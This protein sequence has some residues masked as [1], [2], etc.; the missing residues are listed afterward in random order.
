MF[1]VQTD[2]ETYRI[3]SADGQ[4]GGIVEY[5]EVATLKVGDDIYY[6]CVTDPDT[7]DAD[8]YRVDSVSVVPSEIVEAEFEDEEDDDDETGDGET[9]DDEEVTTE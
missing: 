1:Q 9:G 4:E 8:V 3:V 7:I 5:G 2:E 6:A